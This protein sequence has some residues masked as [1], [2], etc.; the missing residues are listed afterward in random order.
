MPVHY[1]V[2]EE[3]GEEVMLKFVNE[4][5]RNK[6]TERRSDEEF[7]LLWEGIALLPNVTS[8]G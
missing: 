6:R 1:V 5:F 8:I 3:G 2:S 4:D 7:D